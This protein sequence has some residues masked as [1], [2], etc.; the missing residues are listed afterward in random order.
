LLEPTVAS[1]LYERRAKLAWEEL[2]AAWPEVETHVL[3]HSRLRHVRMLFL[4]GRTALAYATE[5]E[6]PSSDAAR[7]LERAIDAARTLERF[8]RPDA[9]VFARVLRA[10]AAMADRQKRIALDHLEAAVE[11]GMH[12][13]LRNLAGYA[14]YMLLH[15][16][17]NR[18]SE[19]AQSAAAR[20]HTMGVRDLRAF[21]GVYA[22]GFH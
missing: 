8:D 22:P 20:L 7:A 19:L 15:L 4:L 14:A 10:G 2:Q 9:R 5:A 11:Q 3:G 16:A 17:P 21:A 13:S 6:T 18:A 1:L 12:G